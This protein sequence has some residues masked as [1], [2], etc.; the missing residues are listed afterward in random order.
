MATYGS[1]QGVEG[2]NAHMIGGY[3]ASTTPSSTQVAT[4]LA[5]GASMIDT[6]LQRAG[7]AVP[8]LASATCYLAVVR[9]NDLFAAAC[10]EQAVNISD[11][12]PGQTTR[13]DKLW[14]AYEQELTY[15]LD[16]DLTTVGVPLSTTAAAPQRR[17]RSLPLR[18]YDGYAANADRQLTDY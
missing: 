13:S 1:E 4:F 16:G 7:Y 18:H 8:V 12:M 3:T 9:L 10:A 15:L 14:K 5:Q 6:T 11:A 2:I 17:V